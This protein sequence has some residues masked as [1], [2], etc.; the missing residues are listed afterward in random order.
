MATLS[1]RCIEEAEYMLNKRS[2]VR[3]TAKHFGLSK[4]TI[5]TDVTSRLKGIDPKLYKRIKRLLATNWS[6]RSYRGGVACFKKYPTHYKWLHG[7]RQAE[8]SQ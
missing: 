7:G 5:H 2:T 6:E 1:A 8:V 4:T 3:K